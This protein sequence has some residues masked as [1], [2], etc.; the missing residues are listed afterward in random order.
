ML[1]VGRA[2]KVM[3]DFPVVDSDEEEEKEFKKELGQWR[4]DPTGTA[5]KKKPKY[6]YKT[7]DELKAKGK[8]AYRSTAASAGELAQVKHEKDVVVSL[9]H[10]SQ[11]LQSRLDTEQDAIQRMEAVLALVE[12]FPTEET[13]PGEEPSLQVYVT[14]S[15]I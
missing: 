14:L 7:A 12:R 3:I 8:M 13:A 1:K 2:D 15:I 10:E 5:G 9:S 4:K 6:S 11:A